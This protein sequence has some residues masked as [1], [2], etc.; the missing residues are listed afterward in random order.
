LYGKIKILC[1]NIFA[2]LVKNSFG[3]KFV[4]FLKLLINGEKI[5]SN[6]KIFD[7]LVLEDGC[8]FQLPYSILIEEKSKNFIKK[9][10]ELEVFEKIMDESNP[11]LEIRRIK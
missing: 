5:M 1:G 4:N 10:D 9:L 11:Y 2:R 3:K 7:L 6:E 8:N